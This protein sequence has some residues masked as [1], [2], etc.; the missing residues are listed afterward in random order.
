MEDQSGFQKWLGMGL[1]MIFLAF[2]LGLA[3]LGVAVLVMG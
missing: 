2:V 3:A 1:V